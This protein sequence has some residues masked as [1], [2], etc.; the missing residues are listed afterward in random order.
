MKREKTSGILRY[1]NPGCLRREIQRF[2][3]N[4]SP[5]RY[6][7]CFL[8]LYGCLACLFYVFKLKLPFILAICGSTAC[9]VPSMFAMVYRSR[10]EARRFED[11]T[12]Y[13]EQMLYSFKRHAKILNSLEDTLVLFEKGESRLYDAVLEAITFIQNGTAENNLYREAFSIIEKEYGCPKLF[14]IHDFLI[15]A[16]AVGGDFTTSADILLKERRLWID[17]VYDLQR[18]KKNIKVKITIGIML[19]FLVC[20][21][22]VYMLP[23]EFGITKHLVSQIVT[24]VTVLLNL[25]IWYAAQVKLSAGL[26]KEDGMRKFEEVKRQYNYVMHR[27][28]H[29][30]TKK[31]CLLAILFV[32]FAALLG[33]QGN[34]TAAGLLLLFS[35]LL[36]TQPR[37]QYKVSMKYVVREVEKTFPDWLMSM[38]LRLQTDNVHVSLSKSAAYAPE[39]LQEELALL[40]ERIEEAPGSVRPYLSFMEKVKLPDVT[41]AMKV[42]YSMAEF[43]ATDINGQIGPLVERGLSMTDRAERLKAEDRLAGISFL[44]L[45]P[46]VTGVVKMLAD[47]GLVMAYI[48]SAVTN[49]A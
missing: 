35:V 38:S 43:G 31:M 3:Y 42:L 41:S 12:A 40:L 15:E 33:K 20:A 10:Y 22:T 18:E 19:S 25:L 34:L 30:E 2:G 16:E 28:L 27:D 49:I 24:M 45:L 11:I 48:L 8:G 4:F 29:K 6:V 37:R 47:L 36:C 13:M 39:I 44:V 17:R 26:I 14:K 32:I 46:M 1:L 5:R 23:K 9:F 21:M 7:E